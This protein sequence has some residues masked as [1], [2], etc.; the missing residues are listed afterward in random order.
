MKI[1]IINFFKCLFRPLLDFWN[2]P[3]SIQ[4]VEDPVDNPIKRKLYIIGTVDEPWQV[5]LLC[6]CG[7]RDKIVL[8]VNDSTK[9]RWTLIIT[10]KTIPSL[11]PSIWRSK[12]CKSHFFLKQG[13]IKWS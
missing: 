4:Y 1:V 13:K 6:P 7:C 10:N 11:S 9:P 3:Y 2:K 12:G 5:E 8:P